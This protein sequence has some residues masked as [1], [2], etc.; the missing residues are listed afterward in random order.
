MELFNKKEM[1]NLYSL[2]NENYNITEFW[3]KCSDNIMKEIDNIEN[4][5]SLKYPLSYFVPTYGYPGNL[6]NEEIKNK[7]NN[8]LKDE[9]TKVKKAF[10][11]CINGYT[12]AFSDYR[13]F[14]ANS[15]NNSANILLNFSESDVG[16]PIEQFNFEGKNHSK[17]SLGYLLGL[18]NLANFTDISKIKSIVEIGGGYGT[19]GEICYKCLPNC[20]YINFDILPTCFFSEYY[21]KQVTKNVYTNYDT[22]CKIKIDE[23]EMISVLPNW[24]IENLEGNIDLFV[25]YISFQEMEPKIVKNYLNQVDRLKPN[26]ILLRNIREGKQQKKDE[27]SVGVL[28]PIKID[29]YSKHLENYK[30]VSS[31][32]NLYGEVKLDNFHSDVLI[33]ERIN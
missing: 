28:E 29:F 16:N 7:I 9:H 20:K 11:Y 21:L 14:V 27:N 17:S 26:W 3:R 33:F 30:L 31:N 6:I 8:L 32:C 12:N 13:V 10:E 5:R 24:N 23:L 4:F 25:N 2:V 18:S 22:K 19:L 1:L 15:E